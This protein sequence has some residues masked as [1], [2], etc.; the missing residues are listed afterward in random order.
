LTTKVATNTPDWSAVNVDRMALGVTKT[1]VL[2]PGL[3]V[4]THL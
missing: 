3:V 1:A 4:S 2:L